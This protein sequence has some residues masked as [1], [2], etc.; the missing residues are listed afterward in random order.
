MF[1]TMPPEPPSAFV[2][3]LLSDSR[4]S[5][6]ARRPTIA[7]LWS[8]SD[9]ALSDNSSPVRYFDPRTQSRWSMPQPKKK[10][11]LVMKGGVTSG[12]VY[13]R[14]ITTL[15]REYQFS[16]IGGTSAGAIA[17]AVTAAAEYARANGK[18]DSFEQVN[19]LPTWLGGTSADGK[20]SN[21][22]HLFQPMNTMADL[23]QVVVAGLGKTGAKKWASVLF[24]AFR[25]FPIASLVGTLPGIFAAFLSQQVS[26]D[27]LTTLGYIFSLALM[28]T[29][30]L[31][32]IVLAM[33]RSISR[34][35]VNGWGIC[36]GMTENSGINSPAL[37]P[38]LS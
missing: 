28:L 12:V 6:T 21:L 29:G 3:R 14:A 2:T 36:S 9:S 27:W 31:I 5:R 10:C 33:L 25:V 20:H 22:F 7:P 26:A 18:D 34:I 35:P 8:P 11:D 23:Y 37:V 16:S 24:A 38:W 30:S 15:S 19:E 32:A 17:A 4:H 13:P 1:T